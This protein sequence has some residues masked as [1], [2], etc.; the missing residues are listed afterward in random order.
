VFVL[1]GSNAFSSGVFAVVESRNEIGATL[2]GDPTRGKPNSYSKTPS[3][4]LPN[5]Q[6]EISC[7]NKNFRLLKDQE[8]PSLECDIHCPMS[9][10]DV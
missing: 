6:L 9:L 10:A 3:F 8:P 5:S 1:I 2:V 4:T 7:C